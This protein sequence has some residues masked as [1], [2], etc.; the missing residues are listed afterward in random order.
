MLQYQVAVGPM[1][2][3]RL[4]PTVATKLLLPLLESDFISNRQ[5][6]ISLI[7]KTRV[8]ESF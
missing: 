7:I 3:I 4:K 8:A 2:L 5:N 6:G 1:I